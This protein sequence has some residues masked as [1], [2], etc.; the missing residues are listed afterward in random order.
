VAF[1]LEKG[2]HRWKFEKGEIRV[3]PG[4]QAVATHGGHIY[5]CAQNRCYVYDLST[6]EQKHELAF[7]REE[8]AA[9]APVVGADGQVLLTM[10]HTGRGGQL[11]LYVVRE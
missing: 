9:A 11:Q 3:G 5:A 1:E 4:L 7:S 8:Q 6:G 10:A 2:S